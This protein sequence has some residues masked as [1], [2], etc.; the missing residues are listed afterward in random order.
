LSLHSREV[1]S[2]RPVLSE[3]ETPYGNLA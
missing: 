2:R 1:E 3:F